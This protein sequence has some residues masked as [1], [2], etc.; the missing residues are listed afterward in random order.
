MP[1]VILNANNSF[2][3]TGWMLGGFITVQMNRSII[4]STFLW[5]KV[6]DYEKML[7]LSFIF[8]IVA[9]CVAMFAND[10]YCLSY[11]EY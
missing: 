7:S 3:L 6:H 8:M 2:A 5:R 1:F 4:G 11:F 9:F 10:I